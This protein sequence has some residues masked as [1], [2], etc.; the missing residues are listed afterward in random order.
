MQQLVLGNVNFYIDEY[1]DMTEFGGEQ[2]LAIRKF[3]GGGKDIQSLGAFDDEITWSGTFWFQDAIQRCNTI[4]TMRINGDPVTLQ[5]SSFSRTVT[6]SK[7]KFKYYNDFYI[8]YSITLEPLDEYA[9][10]SSV[11]G[12]GT[13]QSTSTTSITQ[14]AQEASISSSSASTSS[15]PQQTVYT[16]Q[17]GDTLW[18]LAVIYYGDGTQWTKIA[19]ANGIQ[20]PTKIPDGQQVTVPNP[21]QGV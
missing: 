2:T 14:T 11:N 13:A 8:E 20:D 10:V 18:H 12:I 4:D 3:P 21:T 7:F 6:I 15:Q 5:V 1:P 19:D 17:D 9:G 16:M